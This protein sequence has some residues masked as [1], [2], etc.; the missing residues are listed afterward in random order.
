MNPHYIQ[1]AAVAILT[2]A[3]VAIVHRAIAHAE[4]VERRHA[5][6]RKRLIEISARV[7]NGR[8]LHRDL[9]PSLDTY[10]EAFVARIDAGT[11]DYDTAGARICTRAEW[12]MR[13]QG[14][15]ATAA[16]IGGVA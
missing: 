1:L 13:T 6:I 4:S 16:R 3:A 7:G 10:A 14:A 11:I 12:L 8:S 9:Q 15:T 5:D 2:W